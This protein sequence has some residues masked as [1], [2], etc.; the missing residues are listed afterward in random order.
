MLPIRK[1]VLYKHGVGYFER[2]GQVDG[3]A[4]LDL[5]FRASEMN[6]VLKSLTTLDLTSGHIASISYESTTPLERQLED[7]A[8]RLPAE[9][10]VSGLLKEIKGAR[11][12]VEVAGE[13]VEGLVTGIETLE[14]RLDGETVEQ[15]HL[16]L[17]VDGAFLRTFDLQEVARLEFLDDEL[18]K[19]LQ[20]LLQVLI[21]AKRKD[22]KRLT[23]FAQG[24]GE[25]EILASYIVETPVW[26][27]SYRVLL[28]DEAPLIQGWALVDNPQDEDWVDVQLSLVAGLPISFVHD[29]YS[30]R[31]K[32]RPVVEVDEEEAYAPPMLEDANADMDMLEVAEAAPAPMAR[33]ARRMS[34]TG[35]AGFLAR[36]EAKAQASWGEDAAAA[37]D[38]SVQV[39]TRT[40]EVGDLFEYAIQN[41]VTVKRSQ[42]ALVPILQGP[43]EGDRVA[44]YNAAVRERNPLSAIFF[45]N[46]TGMTLE[47]GPLT[48]LENEAYVGESMLETMK[49]KEERLVPYSVEL[50]CVVSIDHRSR[51]ED[52]RKVKIVDGSLHAWRY[53]VRE[54]IYAIRNKKSENIDLVLEHP[55][56][57]G[58]DLVET[59]KPYEQTDNHYRFRFDVPAEKTVAFKVYE[60]GDETRQY[61]L[62]GVDRDML[63][64]WFSR[65]YVDDETRRL[66]EALVDLRKTMADLDRRIADNEGRI[67]A[68]FADQERQRENLKALGDSQ[69]EKGLRERYVKELTAAE[70]RLGTLRSEIE[71][72]TVERRALEK[73]IAKR[74]ADVEYE[75]TL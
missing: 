50:G 8:I 48:V 71:A 6:D 14:R 74:L 22:L 60:K 9:N 47:G 58:W 63:G 21:D 41:P 42:S 5:H 52:V 11:V 12:A 35:T 51:R 27:T 13:R 64:V 4:A 34:A 72:W 25:R 55:F 49:P 31:Y 61:S 75:A 37:R 68:L 20:H 19:D 36:K 46:T 30:P 1:V 38:R 26:K 10:A 73:E 57:H 45:R 33:A 53:Q 18:Q 15:H 32:R 23:V 59:A 70:E 62:S 69:Q 66:L 40:V 16:A 65:R 44:V 3:D 67:Q 39:Q 29:L 17:L 54:T 24:E 43:F 28:S 7:I 56:V 2:R